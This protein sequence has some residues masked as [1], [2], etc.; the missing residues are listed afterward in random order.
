M[1]CIFC[2]LKT[3]GALSM[4]SKIEAATPNT[5]L[6]ILAMCRFQDAINLGKVW[7]KKYKKSERLLN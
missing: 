7:D 1:P 3:L 4:W 5:E 6:T 2:S